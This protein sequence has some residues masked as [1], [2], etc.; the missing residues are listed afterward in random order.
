MNNGANGQLY[1]GGSS[2]AANG[3]ES[4]EEGKFTTQNYKYYKTVLPSVN[5]RSKRRVN[6]G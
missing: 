4:K 5:Y 3:H 1:N 2:N 6:R